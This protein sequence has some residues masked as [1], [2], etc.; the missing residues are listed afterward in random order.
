[1][2]GL[3][4]FFTPTLGQEIFLKSKDARPNIVWIMADDLGWGEVGLYPSSSPNGRLSTP[5]LEKFGKEG[6]QFMH[7]YAGYTVC[8]PSRTTF[9]TGR[10]GGQFE[11]YGLSGESIALNQNVTT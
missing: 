11:K 5:H 1:M 8:A 3:A 2:G 6:I 4:C 10:H 7:A 9:F